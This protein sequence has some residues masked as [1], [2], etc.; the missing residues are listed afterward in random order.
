MATLI[1][2]HFLERGI[3]KENLEVYTFGTPPIGDRAFCN[4][5]QDKLKLYRMVNE[6]DVVAHLDKNYTGLNNLEEGK[7]NFTLSKSKGWKCQFPS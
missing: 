2:C 7:I 3:N 5:Y 6:N 1:G 4:Y